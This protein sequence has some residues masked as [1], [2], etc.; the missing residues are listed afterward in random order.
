[1]QYLERTLQ[2]K[3]ALLGR[4]DLLE[5][6]RNIFASHLAKGHACEPIGIGNSRFA[7]E[8]DQCEVAPGVRVNLLLKLK[9]D[10]YQMKYSRAAE[11]S[12]CNDWSEFG[13]FE[14]YYNFVAGHLLTV[15][16][17]SKAGY[18]RY[19]STSAPGSRVEFTFSLADNWGGTRVAQGD[20]GAIP[21]FQLVLRHQGWFGQLTEG[22]P[23]FI[24][25]KHT[26]ECCGEIDSDTVENGRI[27]DLGPTQCLL[28]IIDQGGGI[29]LNERYPS[30][31][32]VRLRG[33]KYFCPGN[34][35]DI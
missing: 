29:N 24:K 22:G 12:W 18:K 26:A 3:T 17:R 2:V 8:V 15:S 31:L 35:L 28:I 33:E 20:M 23:S 21:Y 13:A 30:N 4:P 11:R 32:G 9:K 6:M 10:K 1:M 34:R 14:M 5:K 19:R 16:F 27:I 7:Y 25:P